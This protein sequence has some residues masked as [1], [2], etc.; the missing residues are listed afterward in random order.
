MIL[1]ALGRSMKALFVSLNGSIL[2]AIVVSN[3]LID[4]R[5]TWNSIKLMKGSAM[6]ESLSSQSTDMYWVI[7]TLQNDPPHSQLFSA[8]VNVSDDES[9]RNLIKMME[10]K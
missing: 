8:K 10:I 1:T 9:K 7:Q 5:K 3:V 4:M 6:F 2:A